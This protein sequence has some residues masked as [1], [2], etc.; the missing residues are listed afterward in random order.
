MTQETINFFTNL[1]M[2]Q[3]K[4]NLKTIESDLKSMT[5][6]QLKSEPES[7]PGLTKGQKAVGLN[8]NPSGD[9]NVN[10]AKQ[11]CADLI[12]MVHEN[13]T[14]KGSVPSWETNVFRTEAFNKIIAA[15]MAV[16]K[17]ITYKD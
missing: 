2:E 9:P 8:F 4:E 14:H 3:Q 10:K 7:T 16:V 5:E 15:Q 13:Y 12:D 17:F 6:S 11:L 1:A